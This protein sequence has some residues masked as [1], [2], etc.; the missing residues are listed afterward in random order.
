MRSWCRS[1]IVSQ[2]RRRGPAPQRDRTRTARKTTGPAQRS[3]PPNGLDTASTATGP[4]TGISAGSACS[5][6]WP[7]SSSLVLAAVVVDAAAASQAPRSR[8]RRGPARRPVGPE[9]VGRRPDR[10][11][12]R[13]VQSR[14]SWTST[15]PCAPATANWLWQ[16][17]NSATADTEPFSRAVINAKTTL[18]QAFNV[19]QILD[20]AVPETVAQRRDLLTRVVVAAAKADRELDAQ[21]EAFEQAAR[22]GHQRPHPAGCAD[23]ADGRPD[24]P[25][26]PVAAG[27][28]RAAQPIRRCRT[29]FGGRQCRDGQAA[30]E[31]SPSRTSPPRGHCVA[32]PAGQQRGLVDAVRAA[33]SSLGR[34]VRCWMRWTPPATDIN[35]AVAALP[36]AIADIQNGI[37]QADGQLQQGDTAHAGRTRARPATRRRPPS[38]MPRRTAPPT[39]SARSPA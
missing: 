31:P 30:T 37:N 39:H 33:E 38:P 36:A 28:D 34:R 10:R 8:V 20:D 32:R 26:G 12:R 17:R 7:S 9:R 4:S 11:A 18:A 15:T 1:A 21:P 3:P 27:A 25:P 19:R 5:S 22:S 35:R 6:R 24:R 2:R 14:S 23:P 13:P 16:S 29:D